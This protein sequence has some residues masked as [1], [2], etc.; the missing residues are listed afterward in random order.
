MAVAL[1]VPFTYKMSPMLAII[2]LASI[3]L[4]ANYGGSITAVTIK[5]HQELLL[6]P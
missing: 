1:L 6:Q 3:Y 5:I 4:A 2:L